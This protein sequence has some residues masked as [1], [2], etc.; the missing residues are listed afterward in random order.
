M[1][2]LEWTKPGIWIEGL[3]KDAAWRISGQIGRLEDAIL[4]ANVTFNM[5]D[6]VRAS[7]QTIERHRDEFEARSRISR[8]VEA[9]LFPDGLMPMGMP[10]DGFGEEYDKRRVLVDTKVRH[11]MWQRGF[12]PQSL[13]SK[14]PLIF[15]KAFIHALD[16]FD[17]FLGDIA[18][19]PDAPSNLKDIHKSFG[20][21]LPD[22]RGVRN[23]IQH[24]EDRSKGEHYGKKIDVKKVDKTKFPIKGIALVNMALNGN[25]FGTTMSDG[26]YGAVDVSVQ[27]I[28]VLLNTLLEVYSAFEW[29][30]GERLYPS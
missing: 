19:D 24:A 13:L 12:L 18:K 27:T 14:P 21:S 25:K 1:V 10:N 6:Q 26:H 4:E 5:F 3:D 2:I 17:K 29:S 30:G 11:Q 22:L 20:V 23:S 9:E 7:Y 15:A 8:E 16:L 28:D